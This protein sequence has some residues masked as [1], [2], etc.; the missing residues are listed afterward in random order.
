MFIFQIPSGGASQLQAQLPDSGLGPLTFAVDIIATRAL[1]VT[2]SV[3]LLCSPALAL[4]RAFHHDQSRPIVA[5][6]SSSFRDR[7]QSETCSA[8]DKVL[9]LILIPSKFIALQHSLTYL[10]RRKQWP[11]S[12]SNLQQTGHLVS[13]SIPLLAMFILN[14][15]LFWVNLHKK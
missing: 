15:K 1:K 9:S 2:S 7:M 4:F 12:S 3:D 13:I 5:I 10:Q 8:P 11:P 14:G 6:F